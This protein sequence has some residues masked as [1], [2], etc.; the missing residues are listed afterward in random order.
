MRIGVSQLQTSDQLSV[1][2]YALV[3]SLSSS[4]RTITEKQTSSKRLSGSLLRSL[5]A[6]KSASASNPAPRSAC[7]LILNQYSKRTFRSFQRML[8]RQRFGRCS[9]EARPSQCARQ[10]ST[11][12]GSS[13]PRW[14]RHKAVL[15]PVALTPAIT[16]PEKWSAAQLFGARVNGIVMQ[17]YLNCR[18]DSKFESFRI[19]NGSVVSA[20][21]RV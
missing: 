13:A 10:V 2:Q 1:C 4:A 5:R 12:C 16:R 15:S 20:F 9:M 11:R 19:I 8:R 17:S 3:R 6:K 18:H 21:V 14:H 7:S